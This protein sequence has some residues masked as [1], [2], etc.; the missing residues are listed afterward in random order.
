M[1]IGTVAS[2]TQVYPQHCYFV[3]REHLGEE[4]KCVVGIVFTAGDIDYKG[5][6]VEFH[7]LINL[8]Y[9]KCNYKTNMI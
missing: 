6:S 9:V 1:S 4:S 5:V 8:N 3:W 2:Q 7:R